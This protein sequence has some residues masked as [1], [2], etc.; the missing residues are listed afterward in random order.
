MTQRATTPYF[1]GR[2]SSVEVRY[3]GFKIFF[4]IA[5]K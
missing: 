5:G 3:L 4:V 1:Q 2:A